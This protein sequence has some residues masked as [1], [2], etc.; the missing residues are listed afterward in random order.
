MTE[1]IAGGWGNTLIFDLYLLSIQPYLLLVSTIHQV[2]LICFFECLSEMELLSVLAIGMG[3]KMLT[4]SVFRF[5]NVMFRSKAKFWSVFKFCCSNGRPRLL[6]CPL[7]LEIMSNE[8]QSSLEK[9]NHL[10]NYYFSNTETRLE[11]FEQLI[12]VCGW[13]YKWKMRRILTDY[14]Y[15]W[16]T[17]IWLPGIINWIIPELM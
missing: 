13:V 4:S 17:L 7:I 10:S 8:G 9:G 2:K 6:S 3:T 5:V 16:L 11:A 1:A 15:I 12:K 14:R